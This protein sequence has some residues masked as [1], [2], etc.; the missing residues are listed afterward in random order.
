MCK[1]DLTALNKYTN[2]FSINIIVHFYIK[3]VILSCL[4]K[5]VRL[6]LYEILNNSI[7]N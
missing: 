4:F 6:K 1:N 5:K 3:F 7:I 2:T